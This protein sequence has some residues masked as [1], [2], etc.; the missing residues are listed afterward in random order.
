MHTRV[1]T[2]QEGLCSSSKRFLNVS[3]RSAL[4]ISAATVRKHFM[5]ALKINEKIKICVATSTQSFI[6]LFLFSKRLN[7]LTNRYPVWMLLSL[8]WALTGN[9]VYSPPLINRPMRGPPPYWPSVTCFLWLRIHSGIFI[10]IQYSHTLYNRHRVNTE[11]I[12]TMVLLCSYLYC[13]RLR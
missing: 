5:A 2:S 8:I 13:N 3:L 11:M 1:T 4:H 10:Q 7:Y 6:P 9:W 12:S